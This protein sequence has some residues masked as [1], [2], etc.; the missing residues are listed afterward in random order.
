ME[1]KMV[2]STMS[3]EGQQYGGGGGEDLISFDF[4]HYTGMNSR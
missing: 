3:A 2:Y 1:L 4:A